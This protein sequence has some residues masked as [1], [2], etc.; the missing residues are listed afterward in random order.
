MLPP[1]DAEFLAEREIAY[2]EHEEAGVA[3]L[4]FGGWA[5]P[6][7]Y[8]RA[9]ADLLVRLPGGYPDV[10]LDM[11]WFS[12]ALAVPGGGPI[13][14]TDVTEMH[15]GRSWQRW[16]RHFQAGQWHSGVDGLESFLALIASE[17]GRWSGAAA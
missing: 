2:E 4:V 1:A 3:C 13:P 5:L 8:D 7:G 16:S 10:P 6:P 11:W 17:L 15:L 12:P 9:T 14:G